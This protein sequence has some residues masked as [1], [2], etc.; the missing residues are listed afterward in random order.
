MTVHKP[1]GLGSS[2]A[3]TSGTATTSSAL[4]VQTK[5]LRVVA[6]APFLLQLEQI[7]QHQQQIIMFQ[8][9][10]LQFLH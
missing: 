5:A 3:V 4:S 7:Q 8:V 2:I 1:V 10:E 9:E 6:T